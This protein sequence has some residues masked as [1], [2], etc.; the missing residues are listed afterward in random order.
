M[1][2]VILL[3][4]CHWAIPLI[5]S[6]DLNYLQLLIR[7]WDW[8]SGCSGGQ[9]PDLRHADRYQAR[10]PRRPRRC[11]TWA[12]R[13][14]FRCQAA[15][16]TPCR[17]RCVCRARARPVPWPARDRVAAACGD[18]GGAAARAL[19]HS[20]PSRVKSRRRPAD[21]PAR[22][23]QVAA[24]RHPVASATGLRPAG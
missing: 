18:A 20:W 23:L 13:G 15:R 1:L 19:S 12:C 14:A 24:R 4:C 9:Q 17:G 10:R 16:A 21:Q 5:Q 2:T 6:N 11:R 8:F 7:S 3:S 22:H